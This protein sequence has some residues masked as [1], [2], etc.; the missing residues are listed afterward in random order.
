MKHGDE[1]TDVGTCGN[2]MKLGNRIR[3]SRYPEAKPQRW[4]ELPMNECT[5]KSVTL[6]AAITDRLKT[7]SES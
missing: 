3:C 7:G 1:G 2:I 4:E 5:E 6:T